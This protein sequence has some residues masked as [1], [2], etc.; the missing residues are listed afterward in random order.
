MA[1]YEMLFAVT[2]EIYQWRSLHSTEFGSMFTSGI[3]TASRVL[4]AWV[5][6]LTHDRYNSFLFGIDIRH[7]VVIVKHH[8][9]EAERLE[10]AELPIEVLGLPRRGAVR[11]GAFAEIPWTE[12]KPVIVGN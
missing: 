3:K 4:L 1:A 12:A 10:L 6:R 7:G 2:W 9:F 8:R 5:A 11:V